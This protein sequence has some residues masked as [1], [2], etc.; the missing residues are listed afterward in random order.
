MLEMVKEAEYELLHYP[1]RSK[2]KR[3]MKTLAGRKQEPAD[4]INWPNGLLA[5]SLVDYYMQNKNSE[6]ARIIIKCLRKYYDRW[7]KRVVRCIIWMMHS[8]E[9]H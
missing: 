9:W 5:K 6:E 1:K 3:G 7:I 4:K 2:L 8:A